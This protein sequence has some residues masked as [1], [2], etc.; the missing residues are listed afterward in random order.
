M[1]GELVGETAGVSLPGIDGAVHGK[2][3]MMARERKLVLRTSIKDCRV[4]TFAAGGPGG[5]HQNKTSSA[6]RVV[7]PPSGAVGESREER[8]QPLNK[9]KAFRRMAESQKFQRWAR[10]QALN[11]RPID[12]V[13]DEWMRPEN[14]RIEEVRPK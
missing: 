2:E 5:Q 9:R 1:N 12:D 13:V 14:L 10:A 11:L 8:S 3:T 6:V 4:D 7:H